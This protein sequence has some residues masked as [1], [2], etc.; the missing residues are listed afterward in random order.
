MDVGGVVFFL[1]NPFQSANLFGLVVWGPGG[2]DFVG[3]PKMKV[4]GILR[5]TRRIPN[6]QPNHQF[7]VG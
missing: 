6:H 3:S 5:G 2:L 7:T 1:V 4:I